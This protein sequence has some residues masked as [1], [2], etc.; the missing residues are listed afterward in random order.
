MLTDT[1]QK[2]QNCCFVCKI[3]DVELL[4]CSQCKSFY[5][6]SIE[7]QKQDW[8]QHK[9]ICSEIQLQLQREQQKA[10]RKAQGKK[11]IE[12]FAEFSVVGQGNF[13]EI[14]RVRDIETNQIF[15]LKQINKRR[16]TQVNKEKDVFMEKH[17]LGKLAD[18]PYV[19]KLYSTFQDAENLYMQM[20]YV[21]GGELWQIVKNFGAQAFPLC[22]Y[23]IT[24]LIKAIN[25]IHKLGIVHRDIKSE[26][27]LLTQ[28]NQ[29]KLIDFGTARDM[30]DPTIEGSGNGRKE[31]QIMKHFVGTPQFMAPECIRN[32]DSNE[33]S[34]IYSLGVLFYYIAF[35]KY[36]FDGKSDYLIFKQA[37]EGEL[38][39]PDGWIDNEQFRS[40][41]RKMM[42][43][44]PLDR[45]SL[46]EI[47]QDQ[48]WGENFDWNA[49]QDYQTIF[50]GLNEID[51]FTYDLGQELNIALKL[52]DCVSLKQ[53]AD[54]VFEKYG[55]L[56]KDE[57]YQ[58]RVDYM[59][60]I[61]EQDLK[62]MK[63]DT[64]KPLYFI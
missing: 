3:Q 5:Y 42:Q 15:A 17:C 1:Q 57:N 27:V 21:E 58:R 52:E 38:K 59:K 34:D 26:N 54:R 2:P 40:L 32:K 51:K 10:Q 18:C 56:I 36:P 12:D 19:I 6:C 33:K 20:E 49:P 64:Q 48:L 44:D 41:I 31:K 14:F 28:D 23:Y 61:V 63:E 35:G 62:D 9:S 11:D 25:S 46:P 39:F 30:N 8:K 37:T 16:L 43:K 53:E 55:K 50:K 24:E 47:M 45:P 22:L 60:Q 4:R 13:S 7:C 29:I